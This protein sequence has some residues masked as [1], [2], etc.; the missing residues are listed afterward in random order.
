MFALTIAQRY[1]EMGFNSIELVQGKKTIQKLPQKIILSVIIGSVVFAALSIFAGISDVAASLASFKWIYVPVILGLTLINYYFRFFKWDYYLRYLDI[2]ISRK[3]SLAIFLAGLTMSVT[4]AKMGE[5]FKSYLLLNNN[6]T[7][8]SKSIPV[9][10]AERITDALG[11]LILAL[12]SF[13]SFRY[14]ASLLIVILIALVSIIVIIKSKRACFALIRVCESIPYVRRFSNGLRELFG[15]SAQLFKIKPLVVA[16]AISVVS[17]GFE[18]LA[19]YFVLLGFKQADFLLLGT[20][21]F[22]F[23]SLAGAVSIFPGGL[24]VV[25]GS[26]AGLL[27]LAGISKE[28]AA[29]ATVIIRFCT[30]WFGVAVGLL[31]LYVARKRLFNTKTEVNSN[32]I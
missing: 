1:I 15:S 25:E 22:S 26:S 17:W 32:I 5:V 23:S 27:I 20:F 28:I 21:V 19:M 30:L 16:T 14:G 9:V 12:V 8:M 10:L 11:L 24:L 13:P 31:T 4:P 29:A 3:D 7:A 18:C 6:G 2:R